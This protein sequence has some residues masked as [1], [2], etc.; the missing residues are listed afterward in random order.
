MLDSDQ[1]RKIPQVR[2][3]YRVIEEYDDSYPEEFG[4]VIL[5]HIPEIGEVIQLYWL[6]G[7]PANKIRVT[8]VNDSFVLRGRN[9]E[10]TNQKG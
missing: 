10:D 1:I 4:D 7:R 2:Y 5:D 6:S 8:S 9:A 3:V